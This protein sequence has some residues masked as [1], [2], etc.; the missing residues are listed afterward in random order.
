MSTAAALHPDFARK[1]TALKLCQPSL[2]I[3]FS[4]RWLINGFPATILVWT[5]E[6]WAQLTDRPLDAQQFPNGIWC[7]LRID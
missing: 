5:D 1:R 2:D 4:P 7:A 6:E 3:E